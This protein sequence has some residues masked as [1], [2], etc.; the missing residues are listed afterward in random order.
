MHPELA[1]S[2]GFGTF[3]NTANVW[4][5]RLWFPQHLIVAQ[6]PPKEESL[7]GAPARC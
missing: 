7:G 4:G 5:T 2:F 1:C 3:A 6:F